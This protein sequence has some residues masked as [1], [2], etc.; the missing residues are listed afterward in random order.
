[1]E[2]MKKAR[3]IQERG[4][5]SPQ[6]GRSKIPTKKSQGK[7]KKHQD[8]CPAR[9]KTI[10]HSVCHLK[11][12]QQASKKRRHIRTCTRTERAG[13]G[14]DEETVLDDAKVPEGKSELIPICGH[15]AQ[16]NKRNKV[17]DVVQRRRGKGE[18]RKKGCQ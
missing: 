15:K 10:Q 11:D 8:A 1:L 16:K 5:K 12:D 14:D 3:G 17:A 18:D 7:K 4:N 2:E 9:I 6:G 13:Q